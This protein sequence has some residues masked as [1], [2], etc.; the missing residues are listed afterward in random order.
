MCVVAVV[1]F[2]V[3]TLFTESNLSYAI[4]GIERDEI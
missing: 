1:D 3:V 4:V 2:V